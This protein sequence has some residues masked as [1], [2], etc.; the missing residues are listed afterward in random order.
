MK[1]KLYVNTTVGSTVACLRKLKLNGNLKYIAQFVL[2][3][4]V[5]TA[6]PHNFRVLLMVQQ[7]LGHLVLAADHRQPLT[8]I[9]P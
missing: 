1:L 3:D 6:P 4:K 8:F 9:G 7:T 5:G 2:F